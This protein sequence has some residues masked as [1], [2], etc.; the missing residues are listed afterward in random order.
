MSSTQR[1]YDRHKSDYYNT[2]AQAVRDFLS[3]WLVDCSDVGERPDKVFWL[4]PC[5]GGDA[6]HGMAYA[7]VITEEFGADVLTV[8]IR[9]DSRAEVKGDY[10]TMPVDEPKPFVVISN[11][12]FALA[13]EFIEKGLRDVADGG[14]VV[15]LLRLNFLGS[16]D[17]YPFFMEHMPERIYT[18]HR[19]MSFTDD[20]KTDSVEYAHLVWKK[21]MKCN[22]SHLF[23]I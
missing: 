22:Y 19:R 12:P 6:T 9:E 5:A 15:M 8:D 10:L 20:G 4:D 16:N 11:P 3:A 23:I 13:R 1:G 18:H 7:D 21:G 14:Y 17:R 2:P